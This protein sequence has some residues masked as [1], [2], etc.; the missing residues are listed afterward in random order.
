[1]APGWY[2]DPWHQAAWRWFDGRDWTGHVSGAPVVAQQQPGIG[3]AATPVAV[4]PKKP[5]LPSFLS[6]PVLLALLPT[7]AFFG[8][9]LFTTPIAVALGFVPLFIVMPVL[10]WID[11]SEPEPRSAKVHTFLWGMC[12]AGF[13]SVIINTIVAVTLGEVAAAVASAPII[14]EIT[15]A[16]G[17][18]WIVRRKQVDGPID[19]VVYA[20]WTALGF[21]MI[22]N[23]SYFQFA[24]Q[25]DVLV[26]TFVV[27][28]LLTPFAHPLF[29]MWIGLAIGLAVRSR[30]SPWTALWGLAVAIALHAAWNGS[31]TLGETDGGAVILLITLL[32]FISLFLA[33]GIGLRQLNVRDTKR[34][35]QLIPFLASRYNMSHEQVALLLDRKALRQA[36]ARTPDKAAAKQLM[37]QASAMSRLAALFDYDDNPDPADEA[38]LRA[39]LFNT[40]PAIS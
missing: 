3:P 22:E 2:E 13:I 15:K 19:G 17:I 25:E 12:V 38:R 14:E 10:L 36:R 5:M 40:T 29:T 21:A 7:I 4:Q 26:Q 37:M 28:A 27:R 30:K 24:L 1:M 39:Q 18:V 32:L 20:G 8:W 35:Q 6:W 16:L 34:Y 9:A 23:V 11:R 33:S 31:L